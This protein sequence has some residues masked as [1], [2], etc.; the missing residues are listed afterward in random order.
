MKTRQGFV[1]NSSSSSFVAALSKL[2]KEDLD[3]ILEYQRGPENTD[4]WTIH[5]NEDAGLLE[6]YTSMDNDAFPEWCEKRGLNRV[7]FNGG[8]Y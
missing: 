7:R 4:G 3:A 6:G 1:S 8:G 2:S 5:V